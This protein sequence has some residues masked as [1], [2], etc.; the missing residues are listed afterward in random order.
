MSS[1]IKLRKLVV[2]NSF[3]Y[4]ISQSSDISKLPYD[5]THIGWTMVSDG[6][7]NFIDVALDKDFMFG[8]GGDYQVYKRSYLENIWSPAATG[9][10]VLQISLSKNYIYGL[11]LDKNLYRHTY[12]GLSWNRVTAV[13]DSISSFD[14]GH[15]F[16]YAIRDGSEITHYSF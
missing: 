13:N 1:G 14:I 15:N 16:I 2:G 5:N 6:T 10:K 8:I 3:L 11:A 12:S 7:T 9:K 4:A